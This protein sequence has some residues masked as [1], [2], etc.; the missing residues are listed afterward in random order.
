MRW[1]KMDRG[2]ATGLLRPFRKTEQLVNRH[3]TSTTF[4]PLTNSAGAVAKSPQHTNHVPAVDEIQSWV[5]KELGIS[6]KYSSRSPLNSISFSIK[7]KLP[8]NTTN[9]LVSFNHFFQNISSNHDP[10]N[11]RLQRSTQQTN[12]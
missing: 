1:S 11:D 12:V 2:R 7:I 3:N 6:S 5:Y 4:R 10:S 8:S 9:Y